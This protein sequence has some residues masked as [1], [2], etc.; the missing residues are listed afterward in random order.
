[1]RTVH[2][3]IGA[4]IIAHVCETYFFSIKS[5]ALVL[6]RTRKTSNE[7][8]H[9]PLPLTCVPDAKLVNG[10]AN[11]I[12]R[13]QEARWMSGETRFLHARSPL[14]VVTFLWRC[15]FAKPNSLSILHD[16]S[17]SKTDLNPFRDLLF[18]HRVLFI[19]Q[20]ISCDVSCSPYFCFSILF[21]TCYTTVI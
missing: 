18:N 2:R 20:T 13:S 21:I 16:L 12:P 14:I 9:R 19:F 1:M 3:C 6:S 17:I 7:I 5:F 8:V 11:W 4:A 15:Y 10:L